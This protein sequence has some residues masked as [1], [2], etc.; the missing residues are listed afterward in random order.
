MPTPKP[1]II[2]VHGAWADASS[3]SHVIPILEKDGY[4]VTAVQIPLTSAVDDIAAAKRALDAQKGPIV[5]VGHSYGGFVISGAAVGNTNVKALVFCA[6]FAPEVGEKLGELNG[7]FGDGPLGAALVPDSGG[8]LWI[9]RTK[10]QTLFNQ[11]VPEPEGS[12]MAA[13]QKP[14]HSA[15]LGASLDAVAWKTIPSWFMVSQQD[16]MMKPE[17]E[18]FMAKRIGAHTSEINA[19]HVGIVT[20][21]KE[22]ARM[23]E[24]AAKAAN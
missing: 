3:W 19:S 22:I 21:S 24:E 17:L 16:R 11:D 10:F 4:T 6:A 8:F 15:I 12:V 2:L 23:I 7:K 9:D 13:T 14:L 1:S 18:R 5:L 20:H